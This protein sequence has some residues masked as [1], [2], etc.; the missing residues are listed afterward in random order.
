MKVLGVLGCGWL[1]IPLG[2]FLQKKEWRVKAS[3]RSNQ[4]IELL[5]KNG[6]KD[7]QIDVTPEKIIGEE[8]FFKELD[9]LIISLP[10][11]RKNQDS[12]Y[13]KKISIVLKEIE[14]LAVKR[15]VFLSST[16][17][18]GSIGGIYD[19]TATPRPEKPSAKELFKC[20]QL[21][22]DYADSSI[23]IRL[24]GL[25]GEDRNPIFQLQEKLIANPKGSINFITQ[26][27]AIGGI[28]KL[29]HLPLEKG[30][31]FNLVS[32]HHP[33]RKEYYEFMAKKHSLP[34]PKFQEDKIVN[35]IIKSDAILKAT[36]FK[37]K[38][39]NLLIY[40]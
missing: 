19:E 15:V 26:R 23:I 25:I 13:V 34:T 4:G 35:R 22:L 37:F 29:L 30:G 1:G 8:D 11:N 17:V 10:P 12:N 16:S 33:K 40:N 9:C 7:Y 18:Y 24:G 32:P 27:D 20:E 21:V 39:H 28:E 6:L 36:S 2:N 31:I 3:R 38:D 5:Q 14:K